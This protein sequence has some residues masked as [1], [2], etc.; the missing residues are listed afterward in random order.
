MSYLHSTTIPSLLFVS[1]IF[2]SPIKILY[3]THRLSQQLATIFWQLNNI[4]IYLI[5][6]SIHVVITILTLGYLLIPFESV[7]VCIDIIGVSLIPGTHYFRMMSPA[8]YFSMM[9]RVI[10]PECRYYMRHP[11]KTVRNEHGSQD[12]QRK[13][14]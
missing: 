4:N 5:I 2:I 6:K 9:S 3:F 1:S 11:K 8:L 14:W 12:I 13:P 10:W 7:Y